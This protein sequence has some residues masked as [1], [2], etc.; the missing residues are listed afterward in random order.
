MDISFPIRWTVEHDRDGGEL[1]P[2]IEIMILL[3]IDIAVEYF[4]I[5]VC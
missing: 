4:G 5:L 3:D 2:T 1:I